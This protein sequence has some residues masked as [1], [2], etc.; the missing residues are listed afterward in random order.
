MVLKLVN[1]REELTDVFNVIFEISFLSTPIKY[2]VDKE[3][4]TLL[5]DRLMEK[6]NTLAN[7]VMFHRH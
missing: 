2:E 4:D 3:K 7:I 6:S 1:L 5:V